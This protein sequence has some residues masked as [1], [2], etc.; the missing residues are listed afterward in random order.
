MNKTR[1][2]IFA[3]IG[4]M[5]PAFMA[6]DQV[7]ARSTEDAAIAPTQ[8]DAATMALDQEALKRA[9]LELSPVEKLRIAGDRIRLA[10]SNVQSAPKR[11]GAVKQTA[12]AGATCTTQRLATAACTVPGRAR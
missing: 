10:K 3:G 12:S 6:T 8:N 4:A 1:R 7:Q 5:T 9:L 11:A 2:I